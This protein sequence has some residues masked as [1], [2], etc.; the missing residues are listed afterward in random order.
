MDELFAQFLKERRCLK[1]V[2]DRTLG[3]YD[4]CFRAFTSV[5]DCAE[6]SGLTKRT[7]QTLTVRLR[8]RG[9]SPITCNSYAR[10]LNAFLKWLHD[11]GHVGTQLKI[12]FQRTERRVL[13]LLNE[14]QLRTLI[15]FKP[16]NRAQLRAFTLAM[17]LV[18]TGIRIEEAL[19]L[20]T[21]DIDLDNLLVKVRGKGGKE[22]IVPF[23]PA[24]R[25]VLFLWLKKRTDPMRQTGCSPRRP[26][27]GFPNGT[28]RER[29]TSS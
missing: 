4:K 2:T 7:L 27:I 1:N 10:G 15:T 28:Q 5:A 26:A 9:V 6:P 8:D 12:P 25:R 20:H 16:K 24:L 17:L 19:T 29:I 3:Y 14:A 22:R 11:E 18:D 13:Q 21:S 23:S